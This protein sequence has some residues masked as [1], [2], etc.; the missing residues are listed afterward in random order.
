MNDDLIKRTYSLPYGYTVT[1]LWGPG[2][3]L[4]EWDPS[5]PR[6]RKQK[7]LRGGRKKK[8]ATVSETAAGKVIIKRSVI[9]LGP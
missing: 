6:I 2:K 7:T 4:T 8:P 1:F 9:C 5:I 3:L